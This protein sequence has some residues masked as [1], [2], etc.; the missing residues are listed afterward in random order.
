VVPD[1]GGAGNG[2]AGFSIQ[3]AAFNTALQSAFFAAQGRS[4]FGWNGY[5]NYVQIDDYGIGLPF[6]INLGGTNRVHI[7]PPANGGVYGFGLTTL[8]AGYEV[9]EG[10]NAKQGV[11]TL[12]AGTLVVS[13]TSVTVNSRIFLTAQTLGTVSTPQALAVTARTAGTSFTIKSASA[14]DTSVVAYEIFEPTA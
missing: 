1:S 6:G 4:R 12:V 10:A 3:T 13:N 2:Q 9:T 14:S 7:L 5:S 11:A 8:G